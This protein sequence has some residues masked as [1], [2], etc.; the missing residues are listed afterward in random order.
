MVSFLIWAFVMLVLIVLLIIYSIVQI[1]LQCIENK[2]Y[3]KAY[4][5][6]LNLCPEWN[7][8]TMPIEDERW[9]ELYAKK[10]I[11]GSKRKF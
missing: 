8:K 1:V 3:R 6:F 5:D 2:K 4:E 9:I 7:R 10:Q 11:Y